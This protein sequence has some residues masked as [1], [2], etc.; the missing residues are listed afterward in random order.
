MTKIAALFTQ[1]YTKTSIDWGF[2][3]THWSGYSAPQDRINLSG[4][5]ENRFGA[6]P[7]QVFTVKL[8]TFFTVFTFALW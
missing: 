6:G 1:I 5:S 2:D 3:P 7:P 8:M 4:Q